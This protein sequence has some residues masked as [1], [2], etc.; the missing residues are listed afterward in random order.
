MHVNGKVMNNFVHAGS[1]RERDLAMLGDIREIQV[2]RGPGSAVYGAGAL[3]GVIDI[4]TFDGLLD[5]NREDIC[6][7]RL[8]AT[9]DSSAAHAL[10]FGVEFMHGP[11]LGF[12]FVQVPVTA[13]RA[14]MMF[15]F[16]IRSAAGC[17]R[18]QARPLATKADS[19]LILLIMPETADPF[20]RFSRAKTS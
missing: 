2:V 4:R 9:W 16:T 3:P 10:T 20:G 8:L 13:N 7:A 12:T 1:I 15:H 18:P 5:A 19:V 17:N 11:T 14:H 6:T